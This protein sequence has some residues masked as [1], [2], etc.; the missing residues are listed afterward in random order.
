MRSRPD[1]LV[2]SPDDRVQLV[3][4]VKNLRG[5]S[6]EW[7]ADYR[8]NLLAHSILPDAD[9]FLLAFSESLFLW[10]NARGDAEALPHYQAP[11]RETLGPLLVDVGGEEGLEAAVSA[12]LY[13]LTSPSLGEGEAKRRY[14]WLVDS[15]LYS[16]IRGGHVKYSA[17][18]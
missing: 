3:V 11:T 16:R 2:L 5:I 15:G 6:P 18:A 4:E 10:D 7:A 8:R 14:G 1:F 12:W 17:A 13:A 9:F